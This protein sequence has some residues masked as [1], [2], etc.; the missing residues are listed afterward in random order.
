[1]DPRPR[2]GARGGAGDRPRDRGRRLARQAPVHGDRPPRRPQGGLGL[3][4]RPLPVM[5]RALGRALDTA[6]ARYG[7]DVAAIDAAG[8]HRLA[9]LARAAD[10]IAGA[11]TRLAA[12]EPVIVQVSNRA[13]DLA[14]F[15]AVWRAGGV[16]VPA[17]RSMP[18][19][20]LDQLVAATG[21]RALVDAAAPTPV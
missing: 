18:A 13:L 10:A 7:A 9:D 11:L 3:A 8:R 21:A 14:A 16:V 12:D 1:R 5:S 6:L 2:R 20:V 19:A 4:R 17:H 15:L